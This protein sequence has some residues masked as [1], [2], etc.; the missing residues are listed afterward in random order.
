MQPR[1]S[2]VTPTRNRLVLLRETMDSV[3]AQSMADWEHIIV[4][5]GSDDGTGDHVRARAAADPRVRYVERTSGNSGANACRNLGFRQAGADLV[6]FLDSD[7]LLAA[8]C[9]EGRV[10]LMERN[11]DLDFVAARTGVFVERPG[12]I[13]RPS[14]PSETGDDLLRFLSFD[15]PWQT[16]APTWRRGALDR[17][18]G[19][20]EALPSWQDVDL[21]VR[22]IAAGLRYL[23]YAKVDHFMRW[24]IEP[25]KISINQR[26][27]PDHL[28]AALGLFAKFD[29]VIR[30]GPGMTWTRQRAICGLYFFIAERWIDIGRLGDALAC[31]RT[32]R[33]RGLAPAG[34][35][36]AG[37]VLLMLARPAW[38]RRALGERLANKWKGWVRFRIEPEIVAPSGV[39]EQAA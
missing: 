8:D 39:R 25:G 28:A 24:Q 14:S 38:L 15:P 11:P 31:W 26:R 23:R 4:D 17:L 13:A 36:A 16:T 33:Q 32:A 19:F 3:A 1:V 22:A 2:I 9:L 10:R 35:H 12:D 21:H 18:G 29:R 7:D 37:A 20:D 5:D 30:E 27:S 6:V 34:V